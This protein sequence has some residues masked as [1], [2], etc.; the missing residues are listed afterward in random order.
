[1]NFFD[2][3]SLLIAAG[4][5]LASIR[6]EKVSSAK[7]YKKALWYFFAALILHYPLSEIFYVGVFLSFVARPI[8]FLLILMS[9]AFLCRAF[10]GQHLSS[11]I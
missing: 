2:L 6:P 4:L 10:A 1:M 5:L 8:G 7:A 3:F 11:K 9:F